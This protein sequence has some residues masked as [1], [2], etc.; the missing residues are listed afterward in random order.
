MPVAKQRQLLSV[1]FY[2]VAR[3][4][5]A[6]VN[7]F[8][9]LFCSKILSP[10]FYFHLSQSVNV[11][12][13]KAIIDQQVRVL[14]IKIIGQSYKRPNPVNCDPRAIIET[15]VN[16]SHCRMWGNLLFQSI[17]RLPPASVTR[18]GENSSIG[19][20]LRSLWQHFKCLICIWQNFEPILALNIGYWN[21]FRCCKNSHIVS[22]W[23]SHLV[24][25]PPAH[26]QVFWK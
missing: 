19:Q 13:Q 17:W 3:V 26:T 6:I 9:F 21:I 10:I 1:S 8:F 12:W 11:D 15:I 14:I 23:S 20:D 5:F 16:M 22:M 7:H 2:M 24:I 25:L 4:R 18:F